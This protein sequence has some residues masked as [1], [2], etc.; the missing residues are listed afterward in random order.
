MRGERDEVTGPGHEKQARETKPA[1]GVAAHL[2]GMGLAPSQQPRFSGVVY[3]F[4]AANEPCALLVR[5]V[6]MST[7]PL[8]CTL[9]QCDENECECDKGK[10]LCRSTRLP[11]TRSLLAESA[12]RASVNGPKVQWSRVR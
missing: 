7:S 8:D 4:C 12:V 6:R 3:W 10:P 9:D 11:R 1:G 2:A 5:R